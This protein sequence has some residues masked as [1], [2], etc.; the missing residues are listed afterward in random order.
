MQKT[1][2]PEFRFKILKFACRMENVNFVMDVW[3]PILRT[4]NRSRSGGYIYYAQ[5]PLNAL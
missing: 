3:L 5:N 4:I 2:G 1:C